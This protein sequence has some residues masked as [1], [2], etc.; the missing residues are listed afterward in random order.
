[1]AEVLRLRC[2]RCGDWHERE[3][4]DPYLP[5]IC[6]LCFDKA[7]EAGHQPGG[8]IRFV[9]RYTRNTERHPTVIALNEAWDRYV[10]AHPSADPIDGPF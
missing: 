8:T 2:L 5:E 7:L 1:M 9:M 3:V 4:G 6:V 10:A